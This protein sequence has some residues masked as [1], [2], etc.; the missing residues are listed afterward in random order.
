MP[1]IDYTK[2]IEL[3][4][5]NLPTTAD[6]Y[7]KRLHNYRRSMSQWRSM[8]LYTLWHGVKTGVIGLGKA[9]EFVNMNM[10]DIL[11]YYS[12][13]EDY[14]K[15]LAGIVDI[16]LLDMLYMHQA[17]SAYLYDESTMVIQPED[18]I[19]NPL[20]LTNAYT[21]KGFY[22]ETIKWIENGTMPYEET[23]EIRQSLLNMFI[24]KTRDEIR[25]FV[26][27]IRAE[28]VKDENNGIAPVSVLAIEMTDDADS[29]IVT[30]ELDKK[31]F[32]WLNGVLSK[33]YAISLYSVS[34][35]NVGA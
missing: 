14:I 35:E 5:E 20:A 10:A 19:F 28:M 21:F 17:D 31:A 24:S 22:Q 6:A 2:E 9:R 13:N 15:Q 4:N 8:L 7:V 12:D 1:T 33:K 18:I 30:L 34:N 23:Y 29:T 26:N 27:E 11:G 3:F 16:I 32:D 25:A